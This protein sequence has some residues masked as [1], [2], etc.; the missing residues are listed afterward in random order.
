MSE[1]V[2]GHTPHFDFNNYQIVIATPHS[3]EHF[4]EKSPAS[5]FLQKSGW[6]RR[7][8]IIY[9]NKK[10]LP[11]NYNA[12]INESNRHK[13]IIFMHDDVLVEDLFF[14]EKLDLA[15]YKYDIVGLAG[16]KTCDLNAPMPAWHLMTPRDQ[17]VGEVTHSKDKN[18]WT[19][20]FGPTDSRALILDGLFLA[21]NVSKLLDTDT[22]FD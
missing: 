3:K 10:G 8:S 20:V 1:I 18:C 12:F 7:S 15:F 9:N 6:D 11:W 22:R 21:V 17:M 4:N 19:S 14:D 16:S 5:F 13:K 2:L